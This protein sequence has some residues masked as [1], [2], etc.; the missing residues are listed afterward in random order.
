MR[1][2]PATTR[3]HSG[4]QRSGTGGTCDKFDNKQWA[5][6]VNQLDQVMIDLEK[7]VEA[8][9][10]QQLAR[11]ANTIGNLCTHN[12]YH[13]GQIVYVRKL[14]GTWNPDKGVKS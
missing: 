13:I 11:W 10:D 5:D 4:D 9:D 1:S 8:A 6:I 3:K 7:L 2:S 14:Q 12:A